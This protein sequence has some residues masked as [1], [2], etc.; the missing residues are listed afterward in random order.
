MHFSKLWLIFTILFLF[1]TL[2]LSSFLEIFYGDGQWMWGILAW[3][4][5]WSKYGL[6]IGFFAQTSWE[7]FL[8]WTV[9][10]WSYILNIAILYF[11]GFWLEK[12]HKKF[13][14]WRKLHIK[15]SPLF[16]AAIFGIIRDTEGRILFSRRHNTWHLD[17][18]L[19]ASLTCRS[20][21]NA[22][23][24]Y[25]ARTSGRDRHTEGYHKSN[26]FATKYEWEWWKSIFQCILWG[27]GYTRDDFECWA[28]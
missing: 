3:G 17:G 4:L 22:Y 9:F 23:R 7:I 27:F 1:F 12:L 26:T 5:P 2:G 25:D 21:R 20:M 15:R 16:Y 13:L 6:G 11:I 10:F 18:Y 28:W 14:Q 8:S 24:L 19:S